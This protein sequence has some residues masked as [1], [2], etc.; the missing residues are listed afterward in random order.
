MHEPYLIEN[1][2]V[3][4]LSG[5]QVEWF[6]SSGS[7]SFKVHSY[8]QF[9]RM[10]CFGGWCRTVISIGNGRDSHS[11]GQTHSLGCTIISVGGMA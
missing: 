3:V 1:S 7:H 11:L 2:T 5:G 10:A 8:E 6:S 4:T 9:R